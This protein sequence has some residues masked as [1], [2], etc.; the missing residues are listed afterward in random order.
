[1]ISHGVTMIY[2]L[3]FCHDVQSMFHDVL[4]MILPIFFHLW[5]LM[6][7]HNFH[8]FTHDFSWCIK[9]SWSSM[10][11]LPHFRSISNTAGTF[12]VR[13]SQRATAA[14]LASWGHPTCSDDKKMVRSWVV[15]Y[16]G[17]NL[18]LTHVWIIERD[19]PTNSNIDPAMGWVGKLHTFLWTLAIL[20][21]HVSWWHGRSY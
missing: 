11:I 7:F 17:C 18:Y 2:M 20:R 4:Y 3:V 16:W 21:V 13:P 9:F 1:M 15:R 8:A 14:G 19:P 5:F 6:G 12:K 10:S